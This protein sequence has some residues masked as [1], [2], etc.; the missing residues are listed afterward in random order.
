[1]SLYH[2]LSAK[3]TI[4]WEDLKAELLRKFQ[5]TE[6][7][8]HDKFRSVRPDVNESFSAFL[9]RSGH[10]LDRWIE[11]SGITHDFESLRDLFLH[12]QILHSVS[13]DLSIFLRERTF[14]NAEE[15]CK[16]ADQYRS[17]HPG[18][19]FARKSESTV[20]ETHVAFS[21][22]RFR[23]SQCYSGNRG[24]PRNRGNFRGKS[25]IPV[26][27]PHQVYEQNMYRGKQTQWRQNSNRGNY[28]RGSYYPRG[29]PKCW[30]CGSDSHKRNECPNIQPKPVNV[31]DVVSQDTENMLW[32]HESVSGLQIEDCTVNGYAETLL[33]DGVQLQGLENPL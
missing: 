14:E 6:D 32:S 17:A 28:A 1:M 22:P 16:L 8:F 13:R 9:I 5:C 18:K 3:Q 30:N 4:T 31:S 2:T 27:N 12:E 10:L 25:G 15:M 29:G 24:F 19:V 11:L 21:N 33:R 23:G 26:S 7:G 20:F